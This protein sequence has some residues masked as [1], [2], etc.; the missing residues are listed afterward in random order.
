MADRYSPTRP[1]INLTPIMIESGSTTIPIP[2][3]TMGP[4]N[5]ILIEIMSGEVKGRVGEVDTPVN[6]E[7]EI[8]DVFESA[9]NIV[10]ASYTLVSRHIRPFEG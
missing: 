3:S 1:W 5:E 10:N 2:S 6:G 9:I 4:K 7:L 8:H